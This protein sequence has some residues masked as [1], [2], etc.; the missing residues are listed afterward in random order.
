MLTVEKKE[1]V[2]SAHIYGDTPENVSSSVGS[3][4]IRKMR[5]EAMRCI[6]ILKEPFYVCTY[7]AIHICSVPPLYA[8]VYAFCFPFSKKKKT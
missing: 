3:A 4:S 8:I 7:V 5:N 2:C 1:K 6:L